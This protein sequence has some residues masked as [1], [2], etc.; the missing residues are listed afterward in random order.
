[1]PSKIKQKS[2]ARLFLTPQN[3]DLLLLLDKLLIGSIQHKALKRDFN[4]LRNHFPA[5]FT[6]SEK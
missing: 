5:K 4:G 3:R 6:I 1:M 2:T